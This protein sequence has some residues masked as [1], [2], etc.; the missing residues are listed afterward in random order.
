M[1]IF[2]IIVSQFRKILKI[3]WMT[4][5]GMPEKAIIDHL[6]LNP[7][8]GKQLIKNTENF[9]Q[10]ELE[11]LVVYLAK[12]DLI[13]KYSAKE[14]STLLENICFLICQSKFRQI[15]SIKSHWLP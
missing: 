8:I 15:E 13:L 12:S 3:S 7:W 14:A 5:Q 4:N 10:R 11:N 9:T 2:P 6:K 1:N